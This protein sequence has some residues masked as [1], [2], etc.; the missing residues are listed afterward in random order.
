MTLDRSVITAGQSLA[1]PGRW[2]IQHKYSPL[3][4]S[5]ER[6]T[7]NPQVVGSSPTGGAKRDRHVFACR[8]FMPVGLERRLLAS[9]RGLSQPPWL[10]RRKASPTGGN[11]I[12]KVYTSN[13][14]V[15]VFTMNTGILLTFLGSSKTPLFVLAHI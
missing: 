11:R 2:V 6:R 5:V 4:Q 15:P 9:L 13:I 12:S 8:F 14:K 3:A 10:F 1:Y 7:V